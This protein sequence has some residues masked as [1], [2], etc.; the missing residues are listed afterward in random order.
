MTNIV[1]D[2][3]TINSR[4][5]KAVAICESARNRECSPP[6]AAPRESIEVRALVF[7]APETA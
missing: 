2:H 7:W 3:A 6:N 1:E 5:A 4:R